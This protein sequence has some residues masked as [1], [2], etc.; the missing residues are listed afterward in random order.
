MNPGI[1]RWK[2][3]SKVHSKQWHAVSLLINSKYISRDRIGVFF[4]GNFIMASM[5]F[6]AL[7]QFSPV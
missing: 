1:N 6:S 2:T 4:L 3:G 7:R 5:N